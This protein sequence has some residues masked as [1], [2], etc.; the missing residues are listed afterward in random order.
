[1]LRAAKTHP[2]PQA[3]PPENAPWPWEKTIV[4][5]IT[6]SDSRV[7]SI[8]SSFGG[9]NIA[10][11]RFHTPTIDFQRPSPI[12]SDE[13]I[14]FT[15]LSYDV[16]REKPSPQIFRAA[17]EMLSSMLHEE[18]SSSSDYGG[19]DSYE[20]LH[21][22]DDLENDYHG[23]EK[24]GW[25]RVLLQRDPVNGEK[26]WEGIRLTRVTNKQGKSRRVDAAG[27]LMNLRYWR[28]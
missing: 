11:R 26:E 24:A 21:V 18:A 15:I 28:P 5:I 16:G 10:A 27:S 23:A 4:G 19:I 9:L 13:D 1:M 2:H 8:L 14:S 12:S 6:N 7:P 20:K 3:S 17:E 25:G 22:G